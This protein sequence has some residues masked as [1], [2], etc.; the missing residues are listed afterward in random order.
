MCGIQ[1]KTDLSYFYLYKN[2]HRRHRDCDVKNDYIIFFIM[3]L[4]S[5]IVSNKSYAA[6]LA[7]RFVINYTDRFVNSSEYISLITLDWDLIEFQ[8]FYEKGQRSC[9][10][11]KIKYILRDD[12]LKESKLIKF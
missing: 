8:N 3:E 6:N 7:Q 2:I 12:P 9:Y 5:F 4:F 11:V 10:L 1:R